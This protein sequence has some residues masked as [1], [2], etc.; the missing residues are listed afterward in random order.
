MPNWCRG[1]LKVRGKKKD[2]LKFLKNGLEVTYLAIDDKKNISV[3]SKLL[4]IKYDDDEVFVCLQEN[5]GNIFIKET[6][7]AFVI[8]N[9]KW[10]FD[11]TEDTERV[12]TQLID[13]QQA[14][15]LEVEQFASLSRKYH[16]NFRIKG[17]ERGEGF[18]QEFTIVEGNITQY[19][20]QEYS[21][22]VWEVDDPRIGG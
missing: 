17:Y 15:R 21:D 22:Y 14:W 20:E 1:V 18:S 13:I 6:R 4:K 2:L 11:D 9:I 5:E 8:D 7:R 3:N 12:Y 16:I 19:K 10:Y